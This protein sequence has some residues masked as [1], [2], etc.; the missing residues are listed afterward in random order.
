MVSLNKFRVK[1][2]LLDVYP[3]ETQPGGSLLFCA[4]ILFS[5]RRDQGP[6]AGPNKGIYDAQNR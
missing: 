6:P 3:Q 1:S 4:D 5:L 2:R